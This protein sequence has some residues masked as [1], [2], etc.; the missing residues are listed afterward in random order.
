[1]SGLRKPTH[2]NCRTYDYFDKAS[3]GDGT[4][5]DP[6]TGQPIEFKP[7]QWGLYEGTPRNLGDG[8]VPPLSVSAPRAGYTLVAQGVECPIPGSEDCMIPYQVNGNYYWWDSGN[9][10]EKKGK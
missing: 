8:S 5:K 7:K 10:Y 1:M 2:T 9:V 6:E 3:N 4:Y